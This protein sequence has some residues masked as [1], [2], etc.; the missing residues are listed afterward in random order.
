MRERGDEGCWKWRWHRLWQ[1][2]DYGYEDGFHGKPKEK[3]MGKGRRRNASREGMWQWAFSM[4]VA[5][6]GL[7]GGRKKWKRKKG[8]VVY[9]V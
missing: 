7:W 1:L 9:G 5:L 2:V 6:E 8:S 4:G 3:E